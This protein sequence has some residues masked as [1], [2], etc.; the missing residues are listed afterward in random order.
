MV[1]S[2]QLLRSSP[3]RAVRARAVRARALAGDI[4]LVCVLGQ[5][6]STLEL[7]SYAAPMHMHPGVQVSAGKLLDNLTCIILLVI[8][9]M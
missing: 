6:T 1:A 8:F 5:D 2:S 3:D 7:R 9:A 4:V